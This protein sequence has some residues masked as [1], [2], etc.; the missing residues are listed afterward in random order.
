[1]IVEK[2]SSLEIWLSTSAAPRLIITFLRM[3]FST[4]TLSRMLYLYNRRVVLTRIMSYF[5]LLSL[6]IWLEFGVQVGLYDNRWKKLEIKTSSGSN[7]VSVLIFHWQSVMTSVVK[8]S[9]SHNTA[10]TVHILIGSRQNFRTKKTL[11]LML[12]L[13]CKCDT[14]LI[15]IGLLTCPMLSK[16]FIWF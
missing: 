14:K 11:R 4:I 6:R 10:I 9:C 5:M 15:L 12:G 8:F 7:Q 13:I 1:M 3:I 16:I 2:K